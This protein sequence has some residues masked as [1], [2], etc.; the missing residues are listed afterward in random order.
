MG[1]CILRMP[2]PVAMCARSAEDTAVI[3]A[4]AEA[5]LEEYLPIF[6]QQPKP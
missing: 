5:G 6:R 2:F 1:Y 3:E 4:Y